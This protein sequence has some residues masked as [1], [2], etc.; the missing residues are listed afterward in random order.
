M[1]QPSHTWRRALATGACAVAL[2]LAGVPAAGA[3]PVGTPDP[4]A[5]S[6]GSPE[7]AAPVGPTPPSVDAST[8]PAGFTAVG[9]SALVLGL[10]GFVFGLA[11]RV[12]SSARR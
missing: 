9:V 1:E 7:G 3:A 4:G 5:N 10:G 8:S 11:R 2:G 12:R 6:T